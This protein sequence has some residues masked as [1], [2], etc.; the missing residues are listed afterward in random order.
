MKD[1]SQLAF[2]LLK[3]K[4]VQTNLNSIT[5]FHFFQIHFLYLASDKNDDGS[6]PGKKQTFHYVP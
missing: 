2:C 3:A 1:E 5:V 6:S 4:S